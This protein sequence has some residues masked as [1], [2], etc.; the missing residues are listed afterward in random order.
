M[1]ADV[2]LK[3]TVKILIIKVCEKEERMM[4]LIP[5]ISLFF[6]LIKFKSVRVRMIIVKHLK[7]ANL[8]DLIKSES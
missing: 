5:L 1:I 8:I 3:K 7:G 4:A 2:L 6:N